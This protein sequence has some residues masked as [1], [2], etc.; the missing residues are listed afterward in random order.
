[1]G[2]WRFLSECLSISPPL[3]PSTPLPICLS[4]YISISVS[5]Y[6]CIS[7]YTHLSSPH[8]PTWCGRRGPLTPQPRP[9]LLFLPGATPTTTVAPPS[10]P[11]LPP[12]ARTRPPSTPTR[13]RLRSRPRPSRRTT[14]RRLHFFLFFLAFLGDL[15]SHQLGL[16]L[17][18]YGDLDLDGFVL[19]FLFFEAGD[20]SVEREVRGARLQVMTLTW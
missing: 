20:G 8:P 9:R 3:Y 11:L 2:G 19:E 12:R 7:L 6:L 14:R 13:A 16:G 18:E 15:F 4:A 1:M 17:G 10:A 5:P